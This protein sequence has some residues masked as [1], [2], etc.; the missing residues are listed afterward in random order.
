[1]VA[2]ALIL[3]VVFGGGIVDHHLQ[4]IHCLMSDFVYGFGQIQLNGIL[5]EITLCL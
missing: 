5:E 4:L 1:M 3:I 2:K